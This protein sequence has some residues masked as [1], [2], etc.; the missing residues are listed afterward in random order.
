MEY[1]KELA[2]IYRSIKGGPYLRYS[3]WLLF[4]GVTL[5]A[6]PKLYELAL[7]YFLGTPASSASSIAPVVPVAAGVLLIVASLVVFFYGVRAQSR[8]ERAAQIRRLIGVLELMKPAF[9]ARLVPRNLAHRLHTFVTLQ[10]SAILELDVAYPGLKL[11]ERFKTLGRR[12]DKA[13]YEIQTGNLQPGVTPHV[14]ETGA[15]LRGNDAPIEE[16]IKELDRTI[17]QLEQVADHLAPL[18]RD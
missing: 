5:L 8:A 1:L 3:K 9:R 18:A 6:G 12:L 14:N 15:R 13:D 7:Q 17:G 10:D 2:A 11:R 4:G 16:A